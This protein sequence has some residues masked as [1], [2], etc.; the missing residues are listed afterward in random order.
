MKSVY[1]VIFCAVIQGVLTNNETEPNSSA[2]HY[3]EGRATNNCPVPDDDE[4]CKLQGV[5]LAIGTQNFCS[6]SNNFVCMPSY[7]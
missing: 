7:P 4:D 6:I 3:A 5:T 2:S 1:F